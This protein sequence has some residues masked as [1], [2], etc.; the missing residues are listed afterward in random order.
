[1][2]GYL[3]LG[4]KLFENPVKY[5]EGFN[6]GPKL[7]DVLTVDN[8]VQMALEIWGNGNANYP[9]LNNQPHEAGLLSLDISKAQNVLD[10]H[11][12]WSAR[13][14]LE[15]TLGWYKT[16]YQNGNVVEKMI[17][18]ITNYELRIEN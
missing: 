15:R 10:W 12:K 11:P 1:L 17:E 6:F 13:Q 7:D 8:M 14:A 2:H 5:A 18:Q 9:Q 4:A 16:Y 3:T